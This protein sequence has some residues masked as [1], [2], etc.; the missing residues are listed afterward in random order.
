[1]QLVTNITQQFYYIPNTEQLGCKDSIKAQ[2]NTWELQRQN[3][4]HC[5]FIACLFC[6]LEEVF[7]VGSSDYPQAE[8]LEE[9]SDHL[10]SP[11]MK[12]NCLQNLFEVGMTAAALHTILKRN[13]VFCIARHI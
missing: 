2:S 13:K 10:I 1:M 11:Q 9:C 8:V 5:D 7:G 12:I 6:F 4:L 3:Y